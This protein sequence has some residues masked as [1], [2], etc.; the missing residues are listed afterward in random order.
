MTAAAPSVAA[1]R[2]LFTAFSNNGGGAGP[3][4]L[5]ALRRRAFDRFSA[6][7]FPTTRDEDWHYT[8]VTPIAESAF[9]LL[10]DAE[11]RSTLT[12][13]QPFL[14]DEQL[15]RIVFV[16]G[17]YSR[18]LSSTASLPA[19]IHVSTLREALAADPVFVESSLAGIAAIEHNSFAALNTA[20]M[21][22]GVVIRVPANCEL[23]QPL[24]VLWVSD[25]AASGA[26]VFPRLLVDAGAHSRL[27]VIESHVSVG[28]RGYL[29][30]AVTEIRL[31]A[32][33]RVDHHK[34][35][36]EAMDAYHVATVQA[37]QARDSAFHSF[38][39]A[40]GAAISRTNVYTKLGESGG[41][42]RLNGLYM[43]D[44]T[45]HCDHQ[46]FVHHAA[47]ACASRELYKGILDGTSRGVFNGK[48]L[49]DP[50]AQKTDGKQ[51]N[52]ALLLSEH[53]RV[54]TKPQLE[55]FA[56]DVR[57]THGATVGRLDEN[58]MFY[59]KSRGVNRDTARALL[60]YAFAAEVLA[61]IEIDV[62]RHG[63]ESLAFERYNHT[64]L[65]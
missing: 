18:E 51:T 22:D 37:S 34:L 8:S 64:P 15:S 24:H 23:A 28:G 17:R 38:S 48:V 19:T 46:T 39:F 36:R 31:G 53:A 1:Y 41:E 33:A 12:A 6:L 42:A 10:H 59:L 14:V 11:S 52:H 26:A 25:A 55:I 35:Q 29:T 60:T 56:D 54:D 43:L 32:G 58:L 21:T 62:L 47:E 65:R 16:N 45:Q 7:G 3:A 63:L 2:D 50:V 30:N 9:A 13:L 27:S 4:W 40:A 5:P 57:C 20:F 61:T 49:V 44:G